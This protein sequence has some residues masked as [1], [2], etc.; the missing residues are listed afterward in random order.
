MIPE[1]TPLRG[2]QAEAARNDQVILRAARAV[3]IRDPSASV[4][5][6]AKEAGVG[7][8]ALYHRYAGKEAL[9]QTLCSDGLREF[10]EI[11]DRALVHQ[12]DPWEG[13]AECTRAIID[14]DVHSLTA[15]L[16][17]TFTPT[18]ELHGLAA[19][20]NRKMTRLF[21]ATKNAGAIRDDVHVNDLA[22]IFEQVTAVRGNS[23]AR[24]RGLRQRYLT[25][26]LDALRSDATRTRLP[27]TAPTSAELGERWIPGRG[28]R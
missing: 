28:L 18:E 8:S 2:R 1:P 23:D 12:G 24:T 4:S 9:I 15:R 11:V 3:F 14:A 7:I 22:M 10:T 6:V 5:A 21:N 19:S 16:A 25:L 20:A 26:Q 13:F 17:G 27:G